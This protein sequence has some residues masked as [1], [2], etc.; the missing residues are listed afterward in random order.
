MA[1][2]QRSLREAQP[3]FLAWS[4]ASAYVSFF[5]PDFS[6]GKVRQI[7]AT[8]AKR[9]SFM[10]P[11]PRQVSFA[12]EFGTPEPKCSPGTLSEDDEYPSVSLPKLRVE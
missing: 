5:A 8:T 9:R 7:R 6:R 12:N 4:R 2:L 3:T 10:L 1:V 11:C